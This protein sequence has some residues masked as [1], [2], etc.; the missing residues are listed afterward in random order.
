MSKFY[1]T[2]FDRLYEP[3]KGKN[4]KTTQRSRKTATFE[5]FVEGINSLSPV[6]VTMLYDERDG[7]F[8]KIIIK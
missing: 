5:R 6:I 1:S 7:L 2:S 3:H 4:Q 8:G